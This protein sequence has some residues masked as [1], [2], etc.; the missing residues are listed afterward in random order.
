[1][2][3]TASVAVN[4][5]VP[6]VL[7]QIAGLISAKDVINWYTK[8]KKPSW[9]IPTLLFGPAWGVL[10]G[11]MGYAA[12]RVY[13]R[14]AGALPLGL[15]V[16]QLVLNLAWQ[17]LFFNAK[18]FKWAKIDLFALLGVLT[19]TI[20]EFNKVDTQAAQLLGPYFAFSVYALFLTYGIAGRNPAEDHSKIA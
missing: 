19:A 2:G 3:N 11:L 5:G 16:A 4:V 17:P 8:L 7:G 9:T 12:H 20:F 14:G 18:N 6:L 1:M 15:Y 10:Y 13:Q